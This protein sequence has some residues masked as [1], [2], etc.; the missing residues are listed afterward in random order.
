VGIFHQ[1][2]VSNIKDEKLKQINIDSFKTE[3]NISTIHILHSDI[4]GYELKMLEGAEESLQ[5]VWFIFI[6][7]HSNELH[8][9]CMEFLLSRGFAI[10]CSIN[11]D[12][13]YSEDGLIVA[14][15]PNIKLLGSINL[16]K[17]TNSN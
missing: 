3:N 15:N 2:Y 5:D 13:T 16:S 8:K 1:Y 10:L 4:Q 7:T 9:K 11:K 6:S 12:E 14:Q 17:R